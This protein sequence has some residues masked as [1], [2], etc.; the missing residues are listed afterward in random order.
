MEDTLVKRCN[1]PC[2]HAI[3]VHDCD[4]CKD[5]V[6]FLC[7]S[8][9]EK[10]KKVG[11]DTCLCGTPMNEYLKAFLQEWEQKFPDLNCLTC[12]RMAKIYVNRDGVDSIYM[13]VCYESDKLRCI[14]PGFLEALRKIEGIKE[15]EW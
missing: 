2:A 12:F 10:C 13:S 3:D 11:R 9:C 5:C 6:G 8:I 4:Q 15:Y 14:A 7:E 1:Q